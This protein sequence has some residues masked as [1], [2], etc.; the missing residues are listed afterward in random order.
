MTPHLD[1]VSV[2][3]LG[4][5]VHR[6]WRILAVDEMPWL[7]RA[8]CWLV[9]GPTRPIP[10]NPHVTHYRRPVLAKWLECPWCC[11]AWLTVLAY[12]GW[13]WL[14]GVTVPVIYMLAVSSVVGLIVRNL[15]PTED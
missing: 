7:V 10:G 3:V 5:G 15:D 14:D 12:A 8:R 4:L 9:G 11:G 6:A 13:R 1:L 2:V